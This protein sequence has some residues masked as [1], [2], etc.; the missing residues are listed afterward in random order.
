MY[1]SESWAVKK[2]DGGKWIGLKCGSGGELSG[3]PGQPESRTSGAWSTFS[4]KHRWR[5]E[6][7][8]WSCPTLGTSREGG[9]LRR[10]QWCWGGGSRKRGR[11]SMR[12]MGFMRAAMGTSLQ[13]LGRGQGQGH[14]GPHSFVG[15]PGVRADSTACITHS[16]KG[17][18]IYENAIQSSKL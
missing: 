17:K 4:Q 6:R 14:C 2:A 13:E 15:S 10:R 8:N 1:G 16:N 11:P 5:P 7:R 18:L 3:S 9:V 12:W